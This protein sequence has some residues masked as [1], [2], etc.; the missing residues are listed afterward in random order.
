MYSQRGNANLQ[1]SNGKRVS[2]HSV[3][4]K[5]VGRGCFKKKVMMQALRCLLSGA[6]LRLQKAFGRAADGYRRDGAWWDQGEGSCIR[7][8]WPVRR[9]VSIFLQ[10]Y[11]FGWWYHQ[12]GLP[13]RL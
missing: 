2:D 10:P 12:T 1:I 9:P 6:G 11:F 8:V 3:L 7:E 4:G 13:C 5:E